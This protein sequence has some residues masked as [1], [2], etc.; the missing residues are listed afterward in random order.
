MVDIVV[1]G[2][3][4][5][6]LIWICLYKLYWISS[7]ELLFK[8]ADIWAGINYTVFI[9][10]IASGFFYL[11]TIFIPRIQQIK[12]MIKGLIVY[13]EEIDKNEKSIITKVK[14]GKTNTFYTVE[15]LQHKF[16]SGNTRNIAQK[17]FFS[18][19]NNQKELDLLKQML[20]YQEG[21]LS[22]IISNYS[23]LLNRNI[24]KELHDNISIYFNA[25]NYLPKSTSLEK[26]SNQYL[27]VLLHI[28]GISNELRMIYQ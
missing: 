6:C 23:N 2:V 17:D 28:I 19:W 22:S 3:S 25:L 11:V 16:I 7:S 10:I 14:V 27:L 13:L 15:T 12:N 4:I 20:S 5:F 18:T 8:N 9:S 24:L 21:Y 26:R 1:F